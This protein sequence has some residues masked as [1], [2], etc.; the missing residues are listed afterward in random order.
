[1]NL[2]SQ[3]KKF[4]I[5]RYM[6]LLVVT[7]LALSPIYWLITTSLKTT[8]DIFAVPPK[9][10]FSPTLKHYRAMMQSGNFY[11]YALNSIIV[12]S[13]TTISSISLGLPA[14]YGLARH[15]S[16]ATEATAI[17]MLL[18]RMAPPI[19][20]MVPLYFLAVRFN[21]ANT[22]LSL[23][24]AN[25]SFNLPFAVWMLRNYIIL[26]VPINVEEAAEIDGASTAQKL[27]KIVI[28]LVTPGISAVG[29]FC[30]LFA[31]NDFLY[32]LALTSTPQ[33]QT[34]PIAVQSAITARGVAWGK[35]CS[36]TVI[37]FIPCILLFALAHEQMV[38]GLTAM[39]E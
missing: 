9:L 30:F 38:G 34:L 22:R 7:I 23:I 5:F 12:A 15:R 29:I 33:A 20:L 39:K 24:I 31:W 28:P 35:L 18:F 21:L 26:A 2:F 8:K 11:S 16:R 32:P 6:A 1:M 19:I 27:V 17:S 25:T 10:F 14:A 13:L 3:S 36:T 4:Q 37:M